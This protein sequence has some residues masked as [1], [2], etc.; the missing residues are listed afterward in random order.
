MAALFTGPPP[1]ATVALIV[2]PHAP[3]SVSFVIVVTFQLS[4]AELGSV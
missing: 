4:E 3:I 1:E 2:Q